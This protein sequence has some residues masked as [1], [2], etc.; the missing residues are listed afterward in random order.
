[1]VEKTAEHGDQKSGGFSRSCLRLPGHILPGQGQ[2]Q[3]LALNRCAMFKTG[4]FYT[5]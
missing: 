4:V 5:F 3:G 1:V 2:W